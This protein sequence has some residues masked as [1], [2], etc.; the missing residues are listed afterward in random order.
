VGSGH[1]NRESS[2]SGV[3]AVET[4]VVL[5]VS[6]CAIE[7]LDTFEIGRKFGSIQYVDDGND[8]GDED[9]MT[10]ERRMYGMVGYMHAAFGLMQSTLD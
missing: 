10:F 8:C 6:G 5:I 3:V 1:G 4:I 2:N 7:V 9:I